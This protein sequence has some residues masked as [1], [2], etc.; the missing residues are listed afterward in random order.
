MYRSESLGHADLAAEG[1]TATARQML[2]ACERASEHEYVS[3]GSVAC[4]YAALGDKDGA[5]RNLDR[6]FTER[7]GML[8]YLKTYPALGLL[9]SDRRFGELLHRLNL[10]V[11]R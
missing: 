2:A 8:A 5:F 1:R 6:A 11:E 3:R 4:V 10:P 7:D 9:R